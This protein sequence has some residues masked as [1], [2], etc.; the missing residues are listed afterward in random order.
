MTSRGPAVGRN[1]VV[2][3]HDLFVLDNPEWFSRTYVATHAPIL[4]SQL[5]SAELVIAVSDP[6]AERARSLVRR[7]TRVVTVPNAPAEIFRS[8]LPDPDVLATH[9]LRRGGYV[10]AVSSDD[11]RKN[12]TALAAAHAALPEQLRSE[13]P[14]VLAG[15]SSSIYA[16]YDRLESDPT[17]R[18]GYVDDHELARLYGS[19]AVVA[20]PSLDEG[21]GLPAVEALASGADI[22]VSDV[23]VLRWVCGADARYADPTSL[24]S[25]TAALDAALRTPSD[26]ACR[27]RRAAAVRERFS[28]D[29]SAETL[30]AAISTLPKGHR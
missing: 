27:E 22:L 18:L 28:W 21:F 7:G 13:F 30:Y 15:G 23:P 6:V 4:R 26:P 14:L 2:V 8:D 20:F 24:A 29:A 16:S 17:V 12:Q 5:R 25:L 10:L 11:P 3:V 1:H 9:G 19:A